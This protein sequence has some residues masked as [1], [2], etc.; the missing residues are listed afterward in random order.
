[1]FPFPVGGKHRRLCEEC[2]EKL[3]VARLHRIGFRI[4]ELE[5]EN[6]EL[7]EENERLEKL[8][9]RLVEAMEGLLK[10]Y[11]YLTHEMALSMFCFD[12]FG[13]KTGQGATTAINS[14]RTLLAELKGGVR[15]N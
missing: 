3:S 8:N 15:W 11:H 9:R 4:S 7:A 6:Q 1:M 2:W 13:H 10:P 5:A 12:T 14:A